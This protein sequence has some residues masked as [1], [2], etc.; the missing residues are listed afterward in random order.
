MLQ[1]LLH[2]SLAI[3]LQFFERSNDFD[4]IF[5]KPTSLLEF[6]EL[7]KVIEYALQISQGRRTINKVLYIIYPVSRVYFER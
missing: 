6:G 5:D 4:Y 2:N 3:K 7:L 1:I